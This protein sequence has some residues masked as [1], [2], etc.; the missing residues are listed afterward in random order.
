MRNRLLLPIVLLFATTVMTACGTTANKAAPS[1]VQNIHLDSFA[2]DGSLNISWEAPASNWNPEAVLQSTSKNSSPWFYVEFQDLKGEKI[3]E[4]TGHIKNDEPI[5]DTK[6]SVSGS[7]YS[8]K[9]G[10]SWGLQYFNSLKVN[11]YGY[12]EFKQGPTKEFAIKNVPSVTQVPRLDAPFVPIND[13]SDPYFIVCAHG[14]HEATWKNRESSIKLQ[15]SGAN[16]LTFE[17]NDP[18]QLARC[19][20]F[21][22]NRLKTGKTTFSVIASNILGSSEEVVST[23]DLKIAS[24]SATTS[25]IHEN[26]WNRSFSNAQSESIAKTT[27]CIEKGWRNYD[28]SKDECTNSLS[29]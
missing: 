2:D 13:I 22:Q 26:P 24:R 28:W 23:I 29:R 1:E 9:I 15:M 16:K 25:I 8:L 6:F 14:D 21:P 12:N 20:S 10:S 11:I 5:N 19:F 3:L 27:W 17:T 4:T 7:K 18:N